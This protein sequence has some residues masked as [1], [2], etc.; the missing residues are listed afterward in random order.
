[1]NE[2]P[3]TLAD[4]GEVMDTVPGSTLVGAEKKAFS[5]VTL[6]MTVHGSVCHKH[7]TF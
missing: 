1:M 5:H 3:Y 2:F 4:R 6:K 7:F